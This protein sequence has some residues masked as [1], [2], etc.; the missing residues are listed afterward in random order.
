MLEILEKIRIIITEKLDIKPCYQVAKGEDSEYIIYD[1]YLEQDEGFEDDINTEVIYFVTLNY[2][3]TG[4]QGL[5][6]Y[7]K[8]K[9]AFKSEGF[10]F[11]DITTLKSKKEN[12]FGKNYTFKYLK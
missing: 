8:I 10:F 4:K 7:T 6:N 5:K 12:V 11:D 2:W 1:I 3:H 9:E